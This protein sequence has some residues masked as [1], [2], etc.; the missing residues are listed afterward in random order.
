MDIEKAIR[1]IEHLKKKNTTPSIDIKLTTI[2]DVL[3]N[4]L[5]NK[6]IPV[7]QRLPDVRQRENGEPIEFIV[8]IKDA[9]VP[10]VLS[11]DNNGN[12]FDFMCH[13]YDMP[14]YLSGGY[15]VIAWQPL[16]EPYREEI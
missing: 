13:D 5:I 1:Y 15:D 6:W 2:K 3:E 16:P 4:E 10:T 14:E 9:V 11:I 8:M 12:W 7:S